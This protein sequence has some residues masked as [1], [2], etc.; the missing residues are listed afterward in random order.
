MSEVSVTGK[1]RRNWRTRFWA[2]DRHRL[3]KRAIPFFLSRISSRTARSV[4]R[5]SGLIRAW[6]TL[7]TPQ[8]TTTTGKEPKKHEENDAGAYRLNIPV[9]SPK[10]RCSIGCSPK[11]YLPM[12]PAKANISRTLASRG[13]E[14]L[15]QGR[16]ASSAHGASSRKLWVTVRNDFSVVCWQSGSSRAPFSEPHGQVLKPFLAC[17]GMGLQGSELTLRLARARGF[18]GAGFAQEKFSNRLTL[19]LLNLLSETRT[20]SLIGL[21]NLLRTRLRCPCSALGAHQGLMGVT[22]QK[23]CLAILCKS[24]I[25][26]LYVSPGHP[27][28]GRTRPRSLTAGPEA[29]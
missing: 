29:L 9:P 19:R 11:P 28:L 13:D 26:A 23:K 21:S 25:L 18:E 2:H 6:N 7:P 1:G 4:I 24:C 16:S 22:P 15:A 14:Q 3:L 8:P 20:P 10:P 5:S 12:F 27:H 17:S